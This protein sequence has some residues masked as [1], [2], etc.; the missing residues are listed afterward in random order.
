MGTGLSLQQSGLPGPAVTMLSAG[1]ERPCQG[2]AWGLLHSPFPC[3]YHRNIPSAGVGDSQQHGGQ[4]QQHG[5]QSPQSWRVGG[6]DD[7]SHGPAEGI[8]GSSATPA[9][10]NG[11][12]CA[13]APPG[14][15]NLH[16]T[17]RTGCW[18]LTLPAAALCSGDGV[19]GKFRTRASEIGQSIHTSGLSTSCFLEMRASESGSHPLAL[20][21]PITAPAQEPRGC[22]GS[23]DSAP[24]PCVWVIPPC[25]PTRGPCPG[26]PR[27]SAHAVAPGSPCQ[28]A[29]K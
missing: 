2:R 5:G 26:A 3:I 4:C 22:L 16:Q 18:N 9:P 20:A 25:P 1:G 7:V 8:P 6:E 28:L 12:L 27:A 29:C 11:N 13:Q 23:S 14:V 10:S 17:G 15:N 24:H 21:V 19:K